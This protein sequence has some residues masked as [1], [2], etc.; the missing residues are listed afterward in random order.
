MNPQA[1]RHIVPPQARGYPDR[2]NRERR[3]SRHTAGIR[4]SS[5]GTQLRLA[6]AAVRWPLARTNDGKGGAPGDL[7]AG[8]RHRRRR[9]PQA[10][11]SRD[12][13]GGLLILAAT[14]GEQS[15]DERE[16]PGDPHGPR[17]AYGA[18]AGP[19]Q[20]L[21][22]RSATRRGVRRRM[23]SRSVGSAG[24]S[25]DPL[26]ALSLSSSPLVSPEAEAHCFEL[27]HGNAGGG[28][29]QELNDVAS[30]GGTRRLFPCGGRVGDGRLR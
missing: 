30:V 23:E 6:R 14:P 18:A 8:S 20:P 27:I 21:L 28:P 15:G 3:E 5:E 12:P 10:W 25:V 2:S 4:C 11:R 24:P 9:G 17:Y 19:P 29:T 16:S 13:G 1:T 26:P 22:A 7:V